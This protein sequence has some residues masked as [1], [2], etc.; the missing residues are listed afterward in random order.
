MEPQI[1]EQ[2][3]AEMRRTDDFAETL[4]HPDTLAKAETCPCCDVI[5]RIV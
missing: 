1:D 2:G 5:G 3:T 4:R